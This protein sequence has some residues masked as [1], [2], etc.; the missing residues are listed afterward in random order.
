VAAAR[1]KTRKRPRTARQ[2][3]RILVLRAPGTNCDRETG[4]AFEREG[5]EIQHLHV[6]ALL[7]QPKLLAGA[8]GLVFP[9]G[10]SYGDDLGA[11][12]VLGTAIRAKL[13]DPIRRM[14]D[15]GGI[16]LGI[17]NGFQVLVKTG[18]L[19]GFLDHADGAPERA[20]ALASNI[21]NRYED[22]WVTLQAVTERS[23][24]LRR[25]DVIH[26]PVAHAEGR[27]VC[28]DAVLDRISAADQ[29]ALRYVAPDG[30]S[31]VPFPYN[32]NGST[33]DIA[34]L[35]DPTGR[36]LGLMPHPERNQFPWQDPRFHRGTAPRQPEGQ[37]PFRNA[38]GHLR[39][40]FG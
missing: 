20:V 39:S 1:T 24:F 14:V 2:A 22:R 11:G 28:E 38:M 40:T 34:G 8:H 29:V 30:R 35:C 13:R 5:A 21:Q 27:L 10:F 33:D 18:L 36:I 15:R 7:A 23:V 37:L 9:G 4:Y 12:T 16:V 17:C 26:C 19:P 32:P 3:I 25:G 31:P 6:N